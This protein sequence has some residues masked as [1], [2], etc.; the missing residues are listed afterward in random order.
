MMMKKLGLISGLLFLAALGLSACNQGGDPAQA[1]QAMEASETAAVTLMPTEIPTATA[2]PEP[3][4][5]T[6]NQVGVPLA[7]Y[8]ASLAQLQAAVTEI[9]KTTSPDEMRQ[10]VLDDL[11]DETL[12]ASAAEQNGYSPDDTEVQARMEA[13]SQKMGGADA[14][15]AWMQSMGYDEQSFKTELKRQIAAAWQRDQIMD[16]VPAVMEQVRARQILVR[17]E[18]TANDIYKRLQSGMDFGTLAA[19]YDPITSGEL[20][21][22][23]RGYLTVAELDDAVFALQ[24][25]EYTPVIATD[26]GY[27]IIQVE[28]RADDRDLSTDARLTL[29]QKALD[30]WLT[31][32]RADSQVEVIVP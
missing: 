21:W 23:P 30:D 22:F 24:P 14:L 10:M 4:A 32:A 9:G 19:G 31:A 27:V 2:T 17:N 1:T 15:N 7:V 3:M 11:R 25:G 6:V 13:L 18:D 16:S 26:L 12:L 29:Q 28:E 5:L 8:N 20:G